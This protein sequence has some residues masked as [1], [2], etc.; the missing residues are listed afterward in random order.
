[1]SAGLRDLDII[2][3]SHLWYCVD[4]S[5]NELPVLAWDLFQPRLGLH[6]PVECRLSIYHA[7][8]EKIIAPLLRHVNTS[9]Q[10]QLDEWRS[11]H[12]G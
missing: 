11:K 4:C 7:H 2:L 5:M 10:Q 1:M 6:E 9:L 12:G 8:A 3:E